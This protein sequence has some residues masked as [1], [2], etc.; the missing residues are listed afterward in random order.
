[1]NYLLI[2]ITAYLLNAVSVTIDKILLV[3]RL[4]NPALYVFY[5]S[6]FSLSVLFA[7]P[8]TN[9]PD[10]NAFWISSFSTI[11]WTIGAYYMFKALKDGDAS[12]VIPIIGTLIPVILLIMSGLSGTVNLNEIWAVLILIA[13][14]V[15]LI[16]PYLKGKFSGRE[17]LL[18]FVSALLFANSY[19][20]LKIAYNSSEFLPVFVYSKII[21]VPGIIIILLVPFLRKWVFG[22]KSKTHPPVNFWSWTGFLLFIG[23]AAGGA[24]QMMLT[25]AIS[26]ASPAVINS[27]QGIQYVFL[28]ILSLLLAKKFPLAFGEKFTKSNIAGK[29]IGIFFIFIGLWLLS[30]GAPTQNNPKMGVTFSPRYA[31]ELGLNPEEVFDEIV[32]DLKP[33]IVRLPVY[34]DEVEL[35]KG[36]YSF[37]QTEKYLNKLE[38]NGIETVLVVGYKQPRWPECFQPL[39]SKSEQEPEFSKSIL[40]LVE[41]EV[42]TFKK[43][44]SIK[45]WQL[46]NEPFLDFG[47][48]PKPNYN[49]VAEEF[50]LIKSLD[51]RPILMTDSGELSSW[52]PVLSLT[53]IFGTTLYRTVWSPWFGIV[54]YPWPPIF[55]QLK[56]QIVKYISGNTD[57]K[58]IISELQA[59]PWPDEKKSLGQIPIAEQQQ[60]FSTKQFIDNVEYGKQTNMDEI[61]LWGGEW[62]YFMKKNNVPDYWLLSKALLQH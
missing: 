10:T 14:L 6:L 39:W 9:L 21:L 38:S 32:T 35:E 41:K 23:Q 45:Y 33:K 60:L 50:N 28:F 56:G 1:M 42:N 8:F 46:E 61:Y 34:W 47:I 52:I 58:I 22:N 55:Y 36:V 51:S 59:E 5:I 26:L 2:A 30:F 16:L 37:D 62:W 13:G 11:L 29:I 20:L 24:S 3:K 17:L 40:S 27:I 53:D 12:R 25:F 48:C 31:E 4:P 44:D 19:F 43:Y 54:E 18:E 7:A 57:K 15:F 49:R